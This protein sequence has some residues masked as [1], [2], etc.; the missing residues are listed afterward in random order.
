MDY[1]RETE[2][3]LFIEKRNGNDAAIVFGKQGIKVY[4]V[5]VLKNRTDFRRKMIESY[6]SYKLYIR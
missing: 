4:R 2:R 1:G 3:L 6:L 5:C